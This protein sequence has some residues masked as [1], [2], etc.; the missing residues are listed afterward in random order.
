M[1]KVFYDQGFIEKRV[2]VI[3]VCVQVINKNKNYDIF[4]YLNSIIVFIY[5]FFK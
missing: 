5:F 3:C 1:I 2:Y 4:C